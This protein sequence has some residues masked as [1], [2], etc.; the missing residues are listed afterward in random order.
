M[1]DV[2]LPDVDAPL[3]EQRS[4]LYAVQEQL[5]ILRNRHQE[6][7]RTR[8]VVAKSASESPSLTIAALPIEVLDAIFLASISARTRPSTGRAPLQ[9]AHVCR[10]WRTVA[11]SQP[12]LWTSLDIEIRAAWDG[13]MRRTVNPA[14]GHNIYAFWTGLGKGRAGSLTVR[15]PRYQDR[16]LNTSS[17][18][19]VV[20][21]YDI[22]RLRSLET[23]ISPRQFSWLVPRGAHF[24]NLEYLAAAVQSTVI[25][26]I[27]EAAPKL[28]ELRLR[29]LSER[30][31]IQSPILSRLEVDAAFSEIPFESMTQI[32]RDCPNLAYLKC[33]VAPPT[34]RD[35]LGG[36][37]TFP[38]LQCLLLTSTVEYESLRVLALL[39]LP[40]LH[41]IQLTMCG[42]AGLDVVTQ[43]VAR[44]ACTITTLY[45]TEPQNE[46]AP[47]I[48]DPTA[49]NA[50]RD[51]LAHPIFAAVHTLRFRYTHGADEFPGPEAEYADASIFPKLQRLTLDVC[52]VS[53]DVRVRLSQILEMLDCRHE[54]VSLRLLIETTND[55]DPEAHADSWTPPPLYARTLR[56]RVSVQTKTKGSGSSGVFC[57]PAS[58]G[59]DPPRK[60]E[61]H[62]DVTASQQGYGYPNAFAVMNWEEDDA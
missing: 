42:P 8:R 23:D 3:A 6:L 19:P 52:I 5:C 53:G 20:L 18:P 29:N 57:W 45:I 37:S 1:S 17:L 33:S 55:A 35:E 22:S 15:Q 7:T 56:G 30:A 25:T 11:L 61:M 14:Y 9:L 21:S 4:A 43:F 39:T 60:F 50:R 51:W 24:P 38:N 2:S 32:L 16:L 59:T 31:Y 49:S 26:Q 58:I 46:I 27:L 40:N 36:V 44:S 62:A 28:R 48:P 12:R 13:G 10:L 47:L 54:L 34:W 41:T